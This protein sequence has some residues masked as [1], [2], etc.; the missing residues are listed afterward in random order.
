MKRFWNRAFSFFFPLICLHCRRILPA[1]EGR[2]LCAGCQGEIVRPEGW[3]CQDCGRPLPDGGAH[4]F[5]CRKSRDSHVVTIR[6]AGLYKGPLK[7]A[8]LRFKFQGELAWRK[9]LGRLLAETWTR[10]SEVCQADLILPVPLHWRRK[11]TRGYNQSELLARELRRFTE[12]PVG[13]GVLR[14]A[15]ATR[16]QYGLSRKERLENMS[17][18]FSVHRPELVRRKRVLLVDDVCTT[19]ATLRECAK[20]LRR[21]G[22]KDVAALVLARQC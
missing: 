22:A 20:A 14:R 15:R 1:D 5:F 11:I 8:V 10:H 12:L 16:P 6:A 19:G 7:S 21:S 13:Q 18:A 17:R 4:C 2:S 9:P 3:L